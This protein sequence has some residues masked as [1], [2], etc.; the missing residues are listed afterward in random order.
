MTQFTPGPWQAV[1]MPG[2]KYQISGHSVLD[3]AEQDMNARIISETPALL[4]I[5]A[6]LALADESSRT[7]ILLRADAR[8]L[9]ARLKD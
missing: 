5:T 7:L 8:R 6:K 1:S 9:L 3:L 4:D 2:G